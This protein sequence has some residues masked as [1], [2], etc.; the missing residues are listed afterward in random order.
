M[1]GGHFSGGSAGHFSG[2]GG[3]FGGHDGGHFGGHGGHFGHG[4]G[5]F[6]YGVGFGLGLGA[7]YYGGNAGYPYS[8]VY[9]YGP[10]PGSYYDDYPDDSAPPPTPGNAAPAPV[11]GYWYHCDSPSGF[12]PYVATCSHSWQP[13]PA[14]P[15]SG[16]GD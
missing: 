14:T 12:Y 8:N 6:G 16:T 2:G 15:P 4:F 3:H 9:G 11:P 13:V 1:N 10:D 5:G 7:L